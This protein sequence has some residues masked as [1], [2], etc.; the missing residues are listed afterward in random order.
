MKIK[1]T[2]KPLV[3]CI[4]DGWG[5][6]NDKK[7]N[8]V[9]LAKTPNYNFFLRNFPHSKLEASGEYVGLP[10]GQIGNSEVGHMNLGSGRVILQSLPKINLSF[11]KNIVKKNKQLNDFLNTHQTDKTIHILGLCSNGGVHSH[12]DHIIELVKILNEKNLNICLHLFSDGRDSSPNE[13]GNIIKQMVTQLPPKIQI[14]TLIGRYYSMDRD[15]RWERIEKCYN[16]IIN[17]KSDYNC[18]NVFKAIKLAYDRNETDEFVSPTIIGNYNGI[19]TGDSL[20]ITNFRA[21]RVREILEAFLFPKFTHFKRFKDKPPFKNA[22][23]MNEYSEKL[24]PY[25]KSIFKNEVIKDTL[26]EIISRAGLKQLRLA[27]TE[28]YPHVTFFFNGGNERKYFNEDRIMIPSPKVPTYNLK[29]EMSAKQVEKELIFSIQNQKHDLIIINFANPDMV[30]HTGDIEATIKAVETIDTSLANIK[31]A[32]DK[33]NGVIL[34]T[35]DH[36]N[37]EVMWDKQNEAPHTAH[38]TNKVPLIL[39]NSKKNNSF[40]NIN[41]KDGNLA[42]IAPTI[43]NILNL[44]TSKYM[45]GNSLILKS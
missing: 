2:N 44:P 6:D 5:L 10:K 31:M 27:E 20:L 28:K 33:T 29:P 11:K 17:G 38:T 45:N 1:Q 25:I 16:L 23:G 43:L 30:G 9:A 24:N 8:A 34:L 14:S 4:M 19:K 15:N 21:D 39:I 42:D 35:A 12:K 26:G 36:G 3:L 13:F 41:L 32:I 40:T 37:C 22:L 18:E 7:N